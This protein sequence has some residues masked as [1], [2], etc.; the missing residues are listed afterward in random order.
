[1]FNLFKKKESKPLTPMPK[2][3]YD[4]FDFEWYEEDAINK[5]SKMTDELYLN[6]EY[7]RSKKELLEDYYFNDK[8]YRYEPTD[9][10]CTIKDG[11][12][13]DSDDLLIGKVKDYDLQFLNNYVSSDIVYHHG[14]NKYIGEEDVYIDKGFN[15]FTYRIKKV[16]H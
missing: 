8:V 5:Y 16:V 6:D 4:N 13:Y 3:T 1:M 15:Y 11:F 14:K 12:V 10:P 2:Y 9:F 7:D